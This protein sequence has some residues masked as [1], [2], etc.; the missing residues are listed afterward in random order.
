MSLKKVIH[1]FAFMATEVDANI[2]LDIS[3]G[4]AGCDL[5]LLSSL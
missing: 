1:C 3:G 5:L 2:S 4:C